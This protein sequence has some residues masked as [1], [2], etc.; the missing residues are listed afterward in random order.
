M[1]K[2]VIRFIRRPT[3]KAKDFHTKNCATFN[4]RSKQSEQKKRHLMFGSRLGSKESCNI[5]LTLIVTKCI[6]T[7]TVS[8]KTRGKFIFQIHIKLLLLLHA[9]CPREKCETV[10]TGITEGRS[11]LF[12][13]SLLVYKAFILHYISLRKTHTETNKNTT[14][15]IRYPASLFIAPMLLTLGRS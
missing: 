6:S 2:N 9:G 14:N 12:H 15:F 7:T 10:A 11:K 8:W 4:T 5:T 1:K 13:R 3:T